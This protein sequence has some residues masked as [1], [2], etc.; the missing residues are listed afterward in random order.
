MILDVDWLG[1]D[2]GVFY[3]GGF[4]T[5][6][7][8]CDWI[9]PNFTGNTNLSQIVPGSQTGL[10]NGLNLMLDAEAFDYGLRVE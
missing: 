8:I 10:I 6:M 7:G 1:S 5:D 4:E 3:E 9:T 2:F